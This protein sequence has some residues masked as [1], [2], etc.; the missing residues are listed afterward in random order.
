MRTSIQKS[1]TTIVKGSL[2]DVAKATG[3]ALAETFLSA[4]VIVLVDT[5]GSMEATD[6]P[7]GVSRYNA[8]CKELANL[9]ATLPGKIA[10]ISFAST[11]MFCPNGQPFNLSGGTHL[12]EALKFARTADVDDM[13]FV[14][15]SDG[16]PSNEQAALDIAQTYK[17]RIDTIY[18]G[19][20]DDY[21]GREFLV[22]LAKAS[23]GQSVTADRVAQLSSKVQFLLA[24]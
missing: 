22:R 9:Q 8:A 16:Q 6:A 7:G 13:R 14:V 5:S 21:R 23:G 20:Q 10:V 12:A 4:D 15:I 24:A 2:A 17:N 3:A 19:P 1:N 18:V 11:V